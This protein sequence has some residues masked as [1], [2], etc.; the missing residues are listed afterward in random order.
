MIQLHLFQQVPF[1]E[2][3]AHFSLIPALLLWTKSD[4]NVFSIESR[5]EFFPLKKRKAFLIIYSP[6]AC[7]NTQLS[8]NWQT[9]TRDKGAERR[10]PQSTRLLWQKQMCPRDSEDALFSPFRRPHLRLFYNSAAKVTSASEKSGDSLDTTFRSCFLFFYPR[11]LTWSPL[12]PLQ[13]A[14]TSI[15]LSLWIN[16]FIYSAALHEASNVA[17]SW[18]N[19]TDGSC[20]SWMMHGARQSLKLC[21]K[22]SL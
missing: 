21:H 19:V 2:L 12:D 8:T 16:F 10:S 17:A 15:T 6:A 14:A 13:P 11:P 20:Q 5:L 1:W 7:M 18:E 9:G 4:W 3:V 22:V